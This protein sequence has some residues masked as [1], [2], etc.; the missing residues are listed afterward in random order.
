MLEIEYI[1]KVWLAIYPEQAPTFVR[2]TIAIIL[3]D[4]LS[5]PIITANAASGKVK[6]YQLVVG[7]YN[8]MIFPIVY[9]CFKLSLPAY[10]AYIVHFT[11]FF[12]NLFV[13]IRLMKGILDLTYKNYF[14]KVLLQI[15]PILR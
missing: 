1:L 15:I 8:M 6:K 11:V 4:V 3:A 9:I 10:T 7:G 14:Q 2:W 12:T 13:R 5:L